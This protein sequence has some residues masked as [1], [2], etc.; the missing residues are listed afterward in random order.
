M[1]IYNQG[2]ENIRDDNGSNPSA[3]K[4][5]LIFGSVS[6]FRIQKG[7]VVVDDELSSGLTKK[8]KAHR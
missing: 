3:L 5:E 6:K 1:E 8:C 2:A 7:S 4:A